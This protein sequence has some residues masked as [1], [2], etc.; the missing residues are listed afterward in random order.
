VSNGEGNDVTQSPTGSPVSGPGPGRDRIREW[1][2]RTAAS[3]R[4]FAELRWWILAGVL[5]RICLWVY[6]SEADLSGFASMSVSMVYGGGPYTFGNNYPPAWPLLLNI[7]GRGLS[8]GFPPSGFLQPTPLNAILVGRIGIL[9]PPALVA[10][11]FSVAEKALL[12]PFDLGAGLIIY[13]LARSFAS[14]VIAPRTAFALWFLNP[15]V[16]TVSSVHGDY[17][18][19]PTFF[20]LLSFVLLM[21]G[22]PLFAGLSAGIAITLELY[23]IFL[24]PLFVGFIARGQLRPAALR[25][26]A[27]FLVGGGVSA[28]VVLWPP[29]LL[30]Q[31]IVSFS[32]G[33]KVGNQFGGFWI[34]SLTSLPGP[35]FQELAQ[36]LTA[37][38]LIVSVGGSAIAAISVVYLALVWTTTRSFRSE[39]LALSYTMVASVVA[40]YFALP[41]VQPQNLIWLLPFLLLGAMAAKSLRIPFVVVST[42]PVV[43]Y[44][45][46]LGGPLNLFQGLAVFT[47]VVTVPAVVQSVTW[48]AGYQYVVFPLVLVPTFAALILT[49]FESLHLRRVEA[50]AD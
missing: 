14:T 37:N 15:L 18:V 50:D 35:G 22:D 24:I 27:W 36:T 25:K 30:S 13:Y 26:I 48:F 17:D 39:T 21:R 47:R 8:L 12:L 19:I 1:V 6:S 34:W 32:A 5:I 49:L 38:S 44:F 45:I 31:F 23:P 10:P 9:E 43:F 46:G 41:I 4:Y 29:S 33:P 2:R 3:G 7:V 11:V 20:V 40:I 28:L 42:A 16:I